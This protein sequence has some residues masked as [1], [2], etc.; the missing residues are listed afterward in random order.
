MFYGSGHAAN[1][2]GSGHE[3]VVTTVHDLAGSADHIL[4]KHTH[5]AQY[6]SLS[7]FMCVCVFIIY[8]CR[9]RVF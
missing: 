2:S 9:E 5:R 1:E 6:V 7:L 8:L 4:M 3:S